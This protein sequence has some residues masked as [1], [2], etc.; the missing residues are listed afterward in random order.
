MDRLL[1]AVKRQNIVIPIDYSGYLIV[2]SEDTYSDA[3]GKAVS[4][5]KAGINTCLIKYNENKTNAQ[6]LEYAKSCQLDTCIIIGKDYLT[7]KT[8]T[9]MSLKEP[10]EV[11]VPF[12]S[13]MCY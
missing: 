11:K 10:N 1:T 6:Y 12:D 8:V 2:Y 3:L 5:R 7:G 4:L 9:R 13:I